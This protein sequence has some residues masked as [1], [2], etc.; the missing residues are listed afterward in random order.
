MKFN[1]DELMIFLWLFFPK[2]RVRIL[3]CWLA[4]FIEPIELDTKKWEESDFVKKLYRAWIIWKNCKLQQHIKVMKVV[5]FKSLNIKLL[6]NE[7]W[8]VKLKEQFNKIFFNKSTN[9]K[10]NWANFSLK[11]L[12]APWSLK[13]S[14]VSFR[15][16]VPRSYQFSLQWKMILKLS[17]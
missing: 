2:K 5:E 12:K 1:S 4:E 8:I 15:L 7:F 14:H 13:S 9:K 6:Q 17:I 11:S 3:I 10:L 16:S